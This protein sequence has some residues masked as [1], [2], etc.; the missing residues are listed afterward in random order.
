MRILHTSD[1]HLGRGLYGWYRNEEFEAFL[2]WL[3]KLIDEMNVDCLLVAGD[4]FDTSTPSNRAATLYYRFLAGLT[5]TGCQHVVIIGGNHDSP[6]FLNAPKKLL[7]A[8]DIHVVGSATDNLADELIVLRDKAGQPELIVC[9]VPYL[10]DRDV[11]SVEVGESIEDKTRKLVEGVAD[12]YRAI[13]ELAKREKAN[14]PIVAMGHLFTD[15]GQTIDGDGVRELYVGTLARVAPSIFDSSFDYVAL[16]HL[17]VPQKVKGQDHVRYSGSPIPMGFGEADQEKSVCIVDFEGAG[18]SELERF[19]MVI[20]QI[21]VPRFQEL[22]Q[23]KGDWNHI[24]DTID[25]LA[26]SN[27]WLEVVYEGEEIIG[28]L[29]QRLELAVEGSELKVLRVQN[30]RLYQQILI[31]GDETLDDLTPKQVFERCLDA[32]EI[33]DD[34][35]PELMAAYLE[36]LAEIQEVDAQA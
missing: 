34:Q 18:G 11:R 36:I 27:A 33:S 24:S 30:S 35:R 9:A 29:R 20:Q 17:H 12:H 8:L 15:G 16:G 32:N 14:V 2:D 7:E 31:K 3:H 4:V 13:A 19:S 28:D 6:S 21:A 23:I 5:T 25:E 1:W 10:R 22:K 26:D